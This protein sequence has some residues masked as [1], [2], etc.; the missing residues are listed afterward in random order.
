MRLELDDAH[1]Y[2][3]QVIM[4]KGVIDQLDFNDIF[5]KISKKFKLVYEERQKKPYIA[6]FIIRINKV[7]Y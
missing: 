6:E 1:Q 2:F 7:I 3:L 5:D 4:N